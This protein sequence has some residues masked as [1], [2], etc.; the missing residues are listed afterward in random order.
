MSELG[1]ILVDIL[2]PVALILGVGFWVGRRLGVEA[3]SL[4]KVAY[5]VLGPVFIFDILSSADLGA[6]LVVRLVSATIVTMAVAG[7]VVAVAARS[8]GQPSPVVSATVLTTIYGN[9]GNFG[10]AMVAFTFG[11][12]ALP[13]AGVVLIPVNVIGIVFGVFAAGA[14]RVSLAPAVG[15]ALLAPMTLAVIPAM[16]VNTGQV[17]LPLWLAR[18]VD[19]VADAL[20]PMMLL[21]LGVQLAG[22]RRPAL[23]VSMG[24][25]LVGK[26]LV[27]PAVAGA[28]SVVVGLEGTAAGVVI[29]QSAMPA[30]V[31][32]SLVA[33]EHDLVPDRVTTIVLSGTL[34]SVIT[35]PVVIALVS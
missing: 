26:L 31:F 18:P 20:I 28:V 14:Q 3:G 8:V 16:V 9:V 5:W 35:L 34:L 10:L 2:T 30:A 29:L 33:L 1:G 22:M 12:E 27:A 7:V 6:G 11:E 25:P 21:T 15:R 17:T 4:A 19:L 32:T 13:L 23:D 24:I